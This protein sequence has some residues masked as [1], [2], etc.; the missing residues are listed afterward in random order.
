MIP[1]LSASELRMIRKRMGL[2]QLGFSVRFN[3]PLAAVME[4]E[5]GSDV[6]GFGFTDLIKSLFRKS[7]IASDAKRAVGR[8]LL[9][10]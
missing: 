5:R 1:V 4:L 8:R 6:R 2:S 3:F 9:E 7:N 10:N